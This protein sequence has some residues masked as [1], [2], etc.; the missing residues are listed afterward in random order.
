MGKKTT[1]VATTK[2]VRMAVKDVPLNGQVWE[3]IAF[4]K[5]IPESPLFRGNLNFTLRGIKRLIEKYNFARFG[6]HDTAD[7]IEQCTLA[8]PRWA[9]NRG[10]FLG[11]RV[12]NLKTKIT[13][14]LAKTE[15]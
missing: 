13:K 8:T 2:T 12:V 3:K 9:Q 4:L 15:F 10:D 11:N 6:V 7:T 1:K 14:L 5:N